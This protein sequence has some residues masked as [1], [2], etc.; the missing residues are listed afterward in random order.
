[1]ISIDLDIKY[2]L[3]DNLVTNA[4]VAASRRKSGLKLPYAEYSDFRDFVWGIFNDTNKFDV[5]GFRPSDKAPRDRMILKDILPLRKE[6]PIEYRKQIIQYLQNPPS[7]R[8]FYIASNVKNDLGI[9]NS[10]WVLDVRISDHMLNTADMSEDEIRSRLDYFVN[11]YHV[12]EDAELLPIR[13]RITYNIKQ[14]QDETYNQY[15]VDI[16]TKL[17]KS[18]HTAKSLDDIKSYTEKYIGDVWKMCNGLELPNSG[19]VP[20][21]TTT[22]IPQNFNYDNADIDVL[23]FEI[24]LAISEYRDAL[25]KL[26]DYQF[27]DY[28]WVCTLYD[29][30]DEGYMTSIFINDNHHN[31][32]E[33]YCDICISDYLIDDSYHDEVLQDICLT[34]FEEY[35]V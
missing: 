14:V 26:G 29:I 10:Q 13:F 22:Y 30:D 23:L 35:D 17:K 28:C 11:E 32:F 25:V 12:S 16:L 3:S 33:I 31:S 21:E 15:Q 9:V 27:E 2:M 20:I 6:N 7:S 18:T 19:D 4:Y 8:S 24:E 1:M 5:L 34:L